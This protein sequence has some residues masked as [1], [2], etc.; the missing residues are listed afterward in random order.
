MLSID[1]VVSK[2]RNLVG[3][4]RLQIQYP[5]SFLHA[6]II[7]QKYIIGHL[8]VSL[9]ALL[10]SSHRIWQHHL[11]RMLDLGSFRGIGLN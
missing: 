1:T 10:G 3:C 11:Q 8:W 9:L 4:I 2:R 6:V 5:M 7:S